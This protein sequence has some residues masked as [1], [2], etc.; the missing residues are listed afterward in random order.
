MQSQKALELA[1]GR[2]STRHAVSSLQA[3]SNELPDSLCRIT[4]VSPVYPH[5]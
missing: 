1:S 5:Y 4:V 3:S 2:T